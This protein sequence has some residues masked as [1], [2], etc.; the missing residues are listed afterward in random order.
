IE[1][2]RYAQ[3]A[4]LIDLARTVG[5]LLG[6][7]PNPEFRGTPLFEAELDRTLFAFDCAMQ[8]E[9]QAM[10]LSDGWKL[11]VPMDA[12]GRELSD[13]LAA[14]DLDQDPRELEDRLAF[15]DWLEDQAWGRRL[16]EAEGL[17]EPLTESS[18]ASLDP[19]R[20]AQLERLGY[21]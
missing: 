1:A 2:A 3:P 16:D 15:A 14:F 11:V 17:L 6:V 8:R 9:P 7:E 5:E 12:E 4:S 18:E 21:Y 13:P 19:E 10:V 20:R